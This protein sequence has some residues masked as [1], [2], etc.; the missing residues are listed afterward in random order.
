VRNI[1]GCADAGVCPKELFDVGPHAAALTELL[2]QDPVSFQLPR[3][4]KIAFSG[5]ADDCAGACVNDLGLIARQGPDGAQGFAVYAGGGLGSQGQVAQLLEAFIPVSDVHLVAEAIKRVFDKNGNRKN[6][7]RARLRFLVQEIGFER[8]TQLYRE[9]LATLRQE[10]PPARPLRTFSIETDR[11][12]VPAETPAEGFELWRKRNV[13]AQKQKERFFV[14]I[15]VELGDLSAETA[16]QLADLLDRYGDGLLCATPSQN[17]TLRW[18][19]EAELPGLHRAL[20]ALGLAEARSPVERELVSCTGSATCR[21]G[22]CLSQGLATEIKDTLEEAELD[23]DD[24]RELRIHINGCPNSCGRHPI[25][26]IGFFGKA[27]RVGEHLVPC[28]VMQLGGQLGEG[29]TRL[30]EGKETLPAR[31]LPDFLIE[32]LSAFRSARDYPDFEAY[33][34][35]GGRDAAKAIA[36]RFKEI[37]SFEENPDYYTDWTAEVPFSLAGRGAGECSA[38]V[39]DLI[40]VDLASARDA[41]KEGKL[42]SAMTL[43]S[44]AMLITQ[45]EE[46]KDALGALTLFEKLFLD[47]G[48]VDVGFREL[49][50]AAKRSV[51]EQPGGEHLS[52]SAERVEALIVAVESLYENMDQSL[53]FHA[54]TPNTTKTTEGAAAGHDVPSGKLEEI[55]IDREADFQGVTCPLNYV[56][57]KMLLGKMQSGQ[58][59]SV[60]LD[61][62]GGKSVPKSA[63]KDGHEILAR[64]QEGERWRVLI[65]KG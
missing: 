10:A 4:Y 42:R 7:N 41:L 47:V 6:K 32:Y 35:N 43:A 59:L 61:E 48:H 54:G 24:A 25:A 39:F 40:R 56:K 53:R 58:V 16:L 2:L 51:T 17:L 3:K 29:K 19:R 12:L 13:S 44:R 63:E 18:V 33:L 22:I 27:R 9:E 34:S 15:P 38:G 64:T 37:P 60:L 57:T 1:M 8:F 62:A 20:R 46:A 50:Y 14:H 52:A 30:A 5:C 45:G 36:A 49:I 11:P 31:R 65:R 21:L 26:S 55:P 28:Y 23:L